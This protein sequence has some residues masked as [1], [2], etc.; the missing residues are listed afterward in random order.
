ML[1]HSTPSR[2][3]TILISLLDHD[4]LQSLD[5]INLLGLVEL[6]WRAKDRRQLLISTHDR[7][8]GDLLSRKLRPRNEAERTVVIDLDGWSREGP[9]VATREVKCD[10]VRLRLVW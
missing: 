9:V 1:A 8:F 4:P 6:L 3:S 2:R 10:P 5:D 7:R